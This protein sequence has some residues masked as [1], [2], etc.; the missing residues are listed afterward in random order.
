MKRPSP[1]LMLVVLLLG[2]LLVREPR[3]AQVED[4]FLRWLL[5]HSVAARAPVPLTVVE[6]GQD[7]LMTP[8]PANEA[9]PFA[10]Q[11][12]SAGASAISPLEFA[13]FLQSVLE[14]QPGVVAFENVLK[15]RERDRDQE[16]VFL[17]QAMRVPK[18]LL[19]AELGHVTDPDAPWTEIRGFQ[20]VTGKR[21]ELASFSGV[22]RQPAEDLRLISTVGYTNLPEDSSSKIRVPLLFLY[23]GE[24]IPS[25]TLQAILLWLGVTP[26]DV[27][28]V[29]GSHIALPQDRRIPIRADGTVLV[30]PN[31]AKRARRLSF[32]ELLLAAQKRD[33][34]EAAANGEVPLDISEQVVLAR[35]PATPFSA[36]DLFAATIATVQSNRYLRRITVLFDCAVLLLIGAV[37][38]MLPRIERLDLFLCGIAFTAAYCLLTLGMLS[39]WEIWVPGV[40]PIGAAWIAIVAALILRKKAESILIPPPVV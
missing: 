9:P 35:T 13:L 25:F 34:G 29:L 7:P 21:G 40:L 20:Q 4:F 31:A 14:F 10:G 8:G 36:P 19:A 18:L 12:Q 39:R 28:V 23:R 2:L 22:A 30:D 38:G 11:A 6:I 17:D 15:W 24:V 1:W 16:Q 33:T 37:A 5:K 3:F 27:Q 32:N 26:A